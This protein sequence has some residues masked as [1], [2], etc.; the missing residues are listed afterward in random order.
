MC[1]MSDVLQ[2]RPGWL[3]R[4]VPP[5]HNLQ[6]STAQKPLDSMLETPSMTRGSTLC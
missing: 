6:L 3:A 2:R 1:W 4:L 5:R